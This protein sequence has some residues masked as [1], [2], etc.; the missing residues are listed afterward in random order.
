MAASLE[1]KGHE[2]K[3]YSQDLYRWPDSHLTK[4]LDDNNFDAVGIGVCAGYHQYNKLLSISK[5]I[6]KSKNRPHYVIGGHGPAAAPEYFKEIT[7]ADAV[8]VSEAENVDIFQK[9]IL[10]GA[11]IKDVDTIPYPA[12][13]LFP[14]DYYKLLR[15]QN[16][17]SD[18][19]V[20]GVLSGRGCPYKCVFCYRMVPGFRPRKT[21]CIMNEIEHVK[22]VYG[23]TFINFYDE[24][25]MSSERRV[26]EFCEEMKKQ[27]VRWA[28]SGRLNIAN[29]ALMKLMRSAGCVFVNYGIEALDDKVLEIM[30]KKLTVKQIVSG[31]EAT[32]EAGISPGL[33]VIFGNVG[34][35]QRTLDLAV[36]FLLKYDDG[37]QMRTIRPVTPYPGCELY[38]RAI[39][40][41]K[42][43]DAKEFYEKRH[44]NSDLLSVN[45]TQLSDSDFHKALY[46]ANKK[47]LENYFA[48]KKNKTIAMAK[49]LYLK[50]DANFRGFRRT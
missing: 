26:V 42:L 1:Q 49:K 8:V 32:L 5:A 17:N 24:L 46:N 47:L 22:T 44:V 48:N 30:K 34:D 38:Y 33:N 7:N 10:A 16:T 13:H 39:K 21:Q 2:V 15:H 40:E 14:M 9:G 45:F 28:C 23:A 41:G 19:I 50:N 11:P 37:A 3:I 43:K 20:F 31:I 18:D 29:R 27:K 25:L 35:N 6:N 12:R 4:Y 36:K